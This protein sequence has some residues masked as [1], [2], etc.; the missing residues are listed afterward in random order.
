LLRLIVFKKRGEKWALISSQVEE[1]SPRSGH[2]IVSF[3]NHLIVHGGRGG[4]GLKADIAS[5]NTG[6]AFVVMGK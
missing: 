5:Y 3:N 4:D 6:K 1:V 2:S